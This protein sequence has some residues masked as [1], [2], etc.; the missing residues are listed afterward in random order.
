MII[1]CTVSAAHVLTADQYVLGTQYDNN[2]NS[3]HVKFAGDLKYTTA[4]IHFEKPSG[5]TICTSDCV[6]TDNEFDYTMSVG[7]LNEFG[8]YKVSIVGFVNCM[9][10]SSNI[11]EF[12][13]YKAISCRNYTEGD[14][15]LQY[16]TIIKTQEE[17]ESFINLIEQHAFSGSNILLKGSFTLAKNLT[18][19][20]IVKRFDG[21]AT[22]TI[23]GDVTLTA[24][25]QTHMSNLNF[26]QTRLN[27]FVDMY[28]VNVNLG[29]FIS[30]GLLYHCIGTGTGAKGPMFSGCD[31]LFEC[32]QRSKEW[33][34]NAEF[35]NCRNLFSCY[36][37]SEYTSYLNC[38]AVY[39]CT[40][41][42]QNCTNVL[43]DDL[44]KKFDKTG[45]TVEG[46]VTITGDVTVKGETKIQET[47]TL[48]VKDNIIETNSGGATL[49][50]LS[51][52]TINVGNG[53]AYGIVYDPS[54]DGTVRLGYGSIDSNGK[55]IFK[56]NEGSAVA[57]RADNTEMKNNRIV[58]WNADKHRL[59]TSDVSYNDVASTSKSNDFYGA[60]DSFNR[61]FLKDAPLADNDA[62]RLFD[63]TQTIDLAGN[64]VLPDKYQQ[65]LSVQPWKFY[66][67]ENDI[68][69][70]YITTYNDW[71]VYQ[72]W[73]SKDV[74]SVVVTYKELAINLESFKI[75]RA[76]AN[77]NI[78][79]TDHDNDFLGTQTFE[80]AKVTAVPAA[81]NDVIRLEDLDVI[82]VDDGLKIP[83]NKL[84][85]Y[86][87]NPLAY[88][89]S[90]NNKIYTPY[91]VGGLSPNRRIY[92]RS[93][94]NF[95]GVILE[96]S[97]FF[98]DESSGIIQSITTQDKALAI[99]KESNGFTGPYNTFANVV[100][101]NTGI[102]KDGNVNSPIVPL[103]FV[104]N[105]S[106][107]S[108]TGPT[109]Y[110][111]HNNEYIIFKNADHAVTFAPPEEIPYNYKAIFIIDKP[112]FNKPT[113]ERVD[114]IDGTPTITSSS[115]FIFEL[116]YKNST[117]AIAKQL[118]P[119]IAINA[120]DGIIVDK[121]SDAVEVKVDPNKKYLA[122]DS[123][124][125]YTSI[126]IKNKTSGQWEGANYGYLL[127]PYTIVQRDAN[128]DFEV[129][130]ITA[131]YPG[132]L[133]Q[134]A[135]VLEVG[136]KIII[137]APANATNGTLA[138]AQLTR[139]KSIAGYYGDHTNHYLLFNNERYYPMSYG[140]QEGY[141]TYSNAEYESN[142][143]VIKSITITLS[144]GAWVLTS[145]TLPKTNNFVKGVR[146]AA[147]VNLSVDGSGDAQIKPNSIYMITGWKDNGLEN[148]TLN[149]RDGSYSASHALAFVD[150]VNR[151]YGF[152]I[153]GSVVLSNLAK[154]FINLQSCVPAS[155]G[156][157]QVYRV[158]LDN[159]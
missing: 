118:Y 92:Y 126:P 105:K 30:C 73:I 71:A 43:F 38:D 50:E 159:T 109:S 119:A 22:T 66:I 148:F 44:D 136:D 74:S 12:R 62:A 10:Y 26:V 16:D 108:L 81:D 18:L 104:T 127:A 9:Q 129:R 115:Y 23:T 63:T 142:A 2:T 40:G 33:N 143:F 39:N 158:A 100:Y 91:Y 15:S 32:E 76:E 139:L 103:P 146:L 113:F 7:V 20:E 89:L 106:N 11:V 151:S 29:Q 149:H 82:N 45:G 133:N 90:Y 99:V 102:R 48:R 25:G 123:Y 97:G 144:T 152:A 49:L 28:D 59:E 98:I 57:T 14:V 80:H 141:R 94:A 75:S 111:I 3:F 6:V 137:E 138:A 140:H 96:L 112:P 101:F 65:K 42:K 150:D 125:N 95:A 54:G 88:K 87:A 13:V 51:G 153:T 147:N 53:N 77:F 121:D 64:R 117:E 85:S 135:R 78:P 36:G 79:L 5:E 69:Y 8:M 31:V 1:N 37:A 114:F 131:G 47:E 60:Y 17:F 134:C 128:G 4:H 70:R 86:Q 55:F 154:T 107:Y 84:T 116:T 145:T 41:K 83:T 67:Y 124:A 110:V 52:L 120:G 157:L 21:A 155:G 35:E 68:I 72:V 122:W 34:N 19:P 93:Q 27:G 58:Y 56:T 61:I 156:F 24:Q 132:T 46:D 130:R